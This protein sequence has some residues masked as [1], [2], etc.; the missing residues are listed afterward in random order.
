VTDCG[1]ALLIGIAGAGGFGF[2]LWCAERQARNQ[3]VQPFAPELQR[4]RDDL[5]AEEDEAVRAL[6]RMDARPEPPH[7]PHVR[8][9]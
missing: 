3:G 4:L 9:P 6:H 2:V 1:G 7:P 8:W 5:A